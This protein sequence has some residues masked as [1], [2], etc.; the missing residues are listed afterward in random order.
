MVGG[1]GEG[2]KACCVLLPGFVGNGKRKG[3][4]I[5]RTPVTTE[6]SR[7]RKV[8]SDAILCPDA[9]ES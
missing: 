2:K 4:E 5:K 9:A 6:S 3:R 1:R 7:T 8:K